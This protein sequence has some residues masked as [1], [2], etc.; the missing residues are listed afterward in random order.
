MAQTPFVAFPSSCKKL[1]DEAI[2]VIDLY[3]MAQI[4]EQELQGILRTWKEN[5]PGLLLDA[6][7]KRPSESLARYIGKRRSMVLV[8]LLSK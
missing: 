3:Q 8:G 7:Q 2:R 5:V 1:S 4:S 6:D